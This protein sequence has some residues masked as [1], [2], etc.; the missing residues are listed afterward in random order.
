MTPGPGVYKHASKFSTQG[1]S[2][3]P[4]RP[5]TD[6]GDRSKNPGAGAY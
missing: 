1:Q 6:K 3:V 2:I 5:L 4:A